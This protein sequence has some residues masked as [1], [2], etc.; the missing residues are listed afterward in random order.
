MGALTQFGV[1]GLVCW[2]WLVERRSGAERERQMTE[3]HRALVEQCEARDGLIEV[4]RDNTRAMTA[5]EVG[6][7]ELVGAIERLGRGAG[8]RAS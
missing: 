7:R 4:V 2:M 3:S 8:E 6:Q 5:L 1:A